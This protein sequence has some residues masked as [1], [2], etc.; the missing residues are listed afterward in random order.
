MFHDTQDISHLVIIDN[1]RLPVGLLNRSRLYIKTGG[2][3]GYALFAN[4]LVDSLASPE[5][6]VANAASPV[7]TVAA[8]AMSRDLDTLYDPIV[9]VEDD[10][11]F[12]GT[13]TIKGPP[14]NAPRTPCSRRSAGPRTRPAARS[15]F[16]LVR[17]EPRDTHP[18]ER[19]S[20]HVRAHRA[21]QAGRFPGA[22]AAEPFWSPPTPCS[23][24]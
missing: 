17:H 10:G 4:K 14:R 23:A 12:V 18:L 11:R 2:A 16:L 22:S 3:Y 19:D 1:E 7:S 9:V 8:V 6:V 15:E 24:S 21:Q 13:V 5:F 20:Q